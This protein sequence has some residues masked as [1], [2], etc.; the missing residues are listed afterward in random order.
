MSRRGHSHG[1]TSAPPPSGR[2]QTPFGAS[3]ANHTGGSYQEALSA[4]TLSQLDAFKVGHARRNQS[5]GQG[6]AVMGTL[7]VCA[8]HSCH[9]ITHLQQC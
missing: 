4:I 5:A 6:A 2:L 7:A 9:I 1:I 8:P 3:F